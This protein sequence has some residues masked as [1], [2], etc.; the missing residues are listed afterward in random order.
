M[1]CK[2]LISRIDIPERLSSDLGKIFK[3]LTRI[4]L[5]SPPPP[6]RTPAAGSPVF[7][8]NPRILALSSG[9]VC[10]VQT[11]VQPLQVRLYSLSFK[12]V[13]LPHSHIERFSE[14]ELEGLC[15]WRSAERSDYSAFEWQQQLW[16]GWYMEV[17]INV[18]RRV[19]VY[20]YRDCYI[21]VG[22]GGGGGVYIQGLRHLRLT[23][24]CV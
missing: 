8:V 18:R 13:H 17:Y 9:W 1:V 14:A 6:P 12:L 15:Q 11:Y 19:Y 16:N 10:A 20:R 23:T 7:Y 21:A 24:Y 2:L 5:H 4:L 22:Q 3:P